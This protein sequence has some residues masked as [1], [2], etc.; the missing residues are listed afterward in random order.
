[1]PNN[2]S[3]PEI[4]GQGP[5]EET[6]EN[7][8]ES[9]IDPGGSLGGRLRAAR[10]GFRGN[11]ADHLR[12]LLLPMDALAATPASASSTSIRL[13]GNYIVKLDFDDVNGAVRRHNR[14]MS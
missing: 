4:S 3:T 10:F 11:R 6:E 7:L 5:R 2:A 1:M 13:G 8:H 9:A 14:R 12:V